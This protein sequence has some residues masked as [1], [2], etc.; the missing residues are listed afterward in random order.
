MRAFF[1]AL[2]ALLALAG[3]QNTYLSAMEQAGIP[4]RQILQNRVEDA[5][6]AQIRARFQFSRSLDNYR[7]ALQ[8]KDAPAEQYAALEQD[9]RDTE[10]AARA[11]GPRVDTVEQVADALI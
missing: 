7:R 4:K 9:Y 6:Q 2:T 3:C 8:A 10:K 5:R 1:L 11:V